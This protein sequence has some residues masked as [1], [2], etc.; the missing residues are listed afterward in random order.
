MKILLATAD[1]DEIRWAAAAG[2]LDG[3]LTTHARLRA[4]DRNDT[5]LLGEIARVAAVPVHAMVHAVDAE[6]AYRDG[7]ELARISD[8]IVVQLPLVEDTLGAIRRLTNDGVRVAAL[9]VFNAAQALLAARAGASSVVTSLEQLDAV[10]QSG[11]DLV[12]DLRTVFDA[13]GTECDILVTHPADAV[14]FAECARAGAD[15]VA[16]APDV[17]R[18]LLVH[19]LTDR[20]LDRFLSEVAKRPAWTTV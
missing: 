10:G 3:V 1:L 4:A 7:K 20:G 14:Q 9:L 12:H 2:L 16:V 19:P 11:L 18:R 6:D 15:A 8:Q 13:S 5:E 17:L